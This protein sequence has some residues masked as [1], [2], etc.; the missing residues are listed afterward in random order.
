MQGALKTQKLYT[1]ED[2]Q[3]WPDEER[4]EIIDGVAYDMS[5]A[6]LIKHQNIAVNFL[7]LLRQSLKSNCYTAIAPTDVV[8]DRFNVVQPD[9]FVVCDQ[10]KITEKNVQGAPDL[11][12]EILS[13]STEL[14]DRKKKKS[15]YE[16][17]GVKEYITVFTDKNYVERYFLQDGKY[18]ESELFNWDEILRLKCFDIEINLWEIFEKRKEEGV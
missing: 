17:H 10:S 18:G 1:Y 4:W 13:P 16:R 5:P 7:I 14:K 11:I 8:F 9:V 12:I 6:P 2:Y 3:T 15:L